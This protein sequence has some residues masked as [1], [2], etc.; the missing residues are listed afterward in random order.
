MQTKRNEIS[1]CS[2][3]EEEL[4]KNVTRSATVLKMF[5]QKV[6]AAQREIKQHLKF[7]AGR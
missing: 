4:K 3:K 5:D 2:K 7:M 6:T 1:Y